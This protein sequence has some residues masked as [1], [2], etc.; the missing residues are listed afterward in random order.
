LKIIFENIVTSVRILT[1]VIAFFMVILIGSIRGMELAS[2]FIWAWVV[3]I[4][5]YMLGFLVAS[6]LQKINKE[7]ELHPI[8]HEKDHKKEIGYHLNI[9]QGAESPME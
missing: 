3:A 1:G 5:F 8:E 6:I 2:M 9:E 4:I 7:I